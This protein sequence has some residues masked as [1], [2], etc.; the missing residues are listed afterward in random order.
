M[1]QAHDH[2]LVD[3]EE[4]IREI[5][6]KHNIKGYSHTPLER[7]KVNEFLS[8]L[9]DLQRQ[10]RAEYEKLQNE[11]R[12]KNDAF[13]RKSRQLHTELEGLKMQRVNTREQIVGCILVFVVRGS[14]TVC[15][16]RNKVR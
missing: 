16:K 6:D 12:A 2:R 11:I 15:R 8:R 10:Q 9:G 5:S 1:L 13:N 7:E 4:L 3:R 14:L